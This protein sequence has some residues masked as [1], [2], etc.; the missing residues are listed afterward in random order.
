MNGSFVTH[1]F[2]SKLQNKFT[3]FFVALAVAPVLLLG[4]IALYLLGQ[5]H[6]RDIASIELKL[7]DQKI[8]EVQKFF[9][10]TLGILELRV[11][12]TQKSEIDRGEQ[13]FLLSGILEEN[14]AFQEVGFINLEGTETVKINRTRADIPLADVSRLPQFKTPVSGHTYVSDIHYTLVGPVVT[15]AAPVRNRNDEII[16]VLSAEVNL[17]ALFKSIESAKLGSGGY[18]LLFDRNGRLAS[19]PQIGSYTAGADFSAIGRVSRVLGGQELSGLSAEDRYESWLTSSPVAGTGKII[20]DIGWAILAEWPLQDADAV[21]QAVRNQVFTVILLSIIIVLVIVPF[22]VQGLLKP[23]RA[24]K[25]GAEEIEK[26]NFAKRVEI[27]TRDELEDL[28]EGFNRMAQGLKRLQELRDEFV[29]IAAHELRSPVTVVRGYISLILEGDTGPISAQTRDFLEKVDSSQ[30]RLAQLVNDLLE[31]ARSEAGRITIDVSAL[32]IREPVQAS[33]EEVR[34]L[35]DKKKISLH[36]EPPQELPQILADS[37]RIKEIMVN[38]ISNAIKYSPEGASVT[39]RLELKDKEVITHVADTGYGIPKD[40]Q[41]K[42]F[43]KFYRVR[44]KDTMNI[45]GTGLGLFIVKQ[46]V[47]KMNGKMWFESDEGKGTTFSFSL[48]LA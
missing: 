36:Y 25:D 40:A 34:P 31:V 22:F 45:Q 4:L 20:P 17:S 24:L 13:Q 30:Q 47:E 26:G 23:I 12:F 6:Q 2:R 33:V 32:D 1:F 48:P 3:L 37:G 39:V 43:E 11:S 29:F 35:A 7:I 42:M 10:D 46:L 16:Q 15:L 5:S 27:K 21:I 28:G 38:L 18:L 41:G 9:A 44:T 14:K 8:E 19:P